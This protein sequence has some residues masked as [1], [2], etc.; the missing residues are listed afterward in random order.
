MCGRV[1]TVLLL[2]IYLFVCSTSIIYIYIYISTILFLLI[3]LS[4]QEIFNHLDETDGFDSDRR[5]LNVN[6]QMN[7][8]QLNNNNNN[9]NNNV[10]LKPVV[11]RKPVAEVAALNGHRKLPP[12][13]PKPRAGPSMPMQRAPTPMSPVKKVK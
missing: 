1:A 2:F 5:M 9:S 3:L 6:K 11:T 12:S 10:K 13:T 4:N 8:L 7:S